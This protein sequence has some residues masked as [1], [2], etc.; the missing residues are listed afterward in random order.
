MEAEL[1]KLRSLVGKSG[2]TPWTRSEGDQH[3]VTEEKNE[4]DPSFAK[5]TALQEK[6]NY[7]ERAL[8]EAVKYEEQDGAAH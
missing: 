7:H 3:Q 5:R 1:A 2:P 4:K 8:K 6:I